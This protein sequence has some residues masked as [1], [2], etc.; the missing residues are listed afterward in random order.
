MHPSTLTW[1]FIRKLLETGEPGVLLYVL[2]SRGSSPGRQ[3]FFMAISAD[4]RLSGSIGGGIREH[5]LVELARE[6]LQQHE[7]DAAVKKQI[8]DKSAARNQS[9]MICS[10]EQTVW[11]YPL[12]AKDRNAVAAIAAALEA[13]KQGTLQLDPKG[14]YFKECLEKEAT[15]FAYHSD[16]KWSYKTTLGYSNDLTIIG[17]G[18]C[19]LA[20]SRLMAGM[21]FYIRVYDDRAG[22]STMTENDAAHEK[23]VVDS[24][25]ALASLVKP[26][27][28][29]YVV[30]MTMG[31]RSDDQ[32][33]RA[34]STHRFAYL[35]M[36]GS[37]T[38][39]ERLR[40]QYREEGISFGGMQRVH[41]PIGIQ[42]KSQTPA[43]IAVS[44]AA[45]IIS[46]KNSRL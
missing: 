11:L 35:G 22:L 24:Y 45:E 37:A 27:P 4:G 30:I 39:I 33:L 5:K 28:S 44:I 6:M 26:G 20:L 40:E 38:K 8:H 13:N 23:I 15:V 21:D 12:S 46:I 16:E 31:Y 41:A 36:L 32:A 14:I 1:Q 29:H 25:T 42:I 19:S 2:E 9:G 10:G 34:L 18:H 43:E 17:G 3:G 7:K